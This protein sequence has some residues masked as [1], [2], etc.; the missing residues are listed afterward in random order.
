VEKIGINF[1]S[2]YS[3]STGLSLSFFPLFSLLKIWLRFR[4]NYLIGGI[5][6]SLQKKTGTG[7]FL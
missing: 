4:A 6:K 5:P 3:I 2:L 7:K 1:F